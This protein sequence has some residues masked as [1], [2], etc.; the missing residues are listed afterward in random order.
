MSSQV[1]VV[2]TA[3]GQCHSQLRVVVLNLWQQELRNMIYL[4]LVPKFFDLVLVNA[5]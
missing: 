5:T 3:C 4:G 2:K 1:G